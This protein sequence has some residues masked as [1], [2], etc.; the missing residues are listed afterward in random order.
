MKKAGDKKKE[1]KITL[2]ENKDDVH[3]MSPE[4][5]KAFKEN[6]AKEADEEAATFKAAHKKKW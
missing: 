3:T 6:D 2:V 5:S 4:M 1:K